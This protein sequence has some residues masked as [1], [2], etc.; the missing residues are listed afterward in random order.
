MSQTSINDLIAFAVSIFIRNILSTLTF[1]GG[2]YGFVEEDNTVFVALEPFREVKLS[3]LSI[4][5]FCVYFE[6]RESIHE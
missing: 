6:V 2:I 1:C 5:L 3:S 4:H